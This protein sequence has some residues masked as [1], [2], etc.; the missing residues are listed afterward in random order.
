M[1]FW[2]VYILLWSHTTVLSCLVVVYIFLL[3]KGSRSKY[4]FGYDGNDCISTTQV[5][6]LISEMKSCLLYNILSWLFF[7]KNHVCLSEFFV[8]TTVGYFFSCMFFCQRQRRIVYLQCLSCQKEMLL[9]EISCTHSFLL[10]LLLRKLWTTCHAWYIYHCVFNSSE[11]FSFLVLVKWNI[12]FQ[13]SDE[14]FHLGTMDVGYWPWC[15]LKDRVC[16][17]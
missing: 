3:W 16:D 12:F 10:V 13:E 6:C 8:W 9:V 14:F 11:Y 15:L 7:H 17:A 5:A 1:H 4:T 2:I